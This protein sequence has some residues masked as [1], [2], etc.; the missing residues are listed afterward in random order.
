MRRIGL[1]L[2]ALRWIAEVAS[3]AESVRIDLTNLEANLPII[4]LEAKEQV[5][6]ERK[7]PCRVR[8]AMPKGAEAENTGSLAG[9]VRFHGASSQMYPKKSFAITL[10]APARWL[11]LRESS[12]TKNCES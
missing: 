2:L 5:V 10:A 9:V 8:M 4:Y 6:S 7:V 11:G 1:L 3:G 12:Q